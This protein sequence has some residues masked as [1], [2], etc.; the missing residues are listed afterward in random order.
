MEKK[1]A[2]QLAQLQNQYPE[3]EIQLWAMDEHRLGLKPIARRVWTPIGE[4]PVANVNWRFQ[5]LWLYGFVHPQSGETYWWILPKVNIQLFNRVLADF[6]SHFALGQNKRILLALDGAGWHTSELLEVPDGID[7]IF[8]PPHSRELQPAE[9]LWPLTNE[10]IA[11]C[12]FDTL[13]QLEEVLFHRCRILLRQRD[14]IRG[15]TCFHWWPLT[16]L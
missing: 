8:M 16:T 4:Q 11:N 7:L 2:E 1:L 12:T 10:P 14:L 5:W 13:D 9:R 3:A 15:L 6:A